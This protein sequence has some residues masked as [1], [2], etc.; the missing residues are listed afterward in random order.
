MNARAIRTGFWSSST[1]FFASAVAV[2]AANFAGVFAPPGQ[3]PPPPVEGGDEEEMDE[4]KL[5]YADWDKFQ[6]PDG[7]G[8][9]WLVR[10]G[11]AQPVIAER[12]RPETEPVKRTKADTLRSMISVERGFLPNQVKIKFSGASRPAKSFY[13]IGEEIP[14]PGGETAKLVALRGTN[15]E[16]VATFEFQGE[17]IELPWKVGKSSGGFTPAA[18]E[19]EDPGWQDQPVEE[20]EPYGEDMPDEEI[21]EYQPEESGEGFAAVKS[22]QVDPDHWKI[23]PDEWVEVG[24]NLK[25]YASDVEP[26]VVMGKDGDVLGLKLQNVKEGSLAWQRGFRTG[27]IVQR[28]NGDAVTSVED[29]STLMEKHKATAQVFIQV[30]RVGRR[31]T[32]TFELA[33]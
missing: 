21:P 14:L 32:M 30:D 19:G 22:E 2:C 15:D 3:K 11:E 28:V 26:V 24:N 4:E 29:L 10:T 1:I 27:D 16:G 20:P 5:A 25:S 9:I 33:E 12:D 13:A 23:A 6:D 8:A 18:G 7:Y 17:R 31:L